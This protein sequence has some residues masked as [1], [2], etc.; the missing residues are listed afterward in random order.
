MKNIYYKLIK[1]NVVP[2]GSVNQ[3]TVFTSD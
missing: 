1:P 2:D 3:I